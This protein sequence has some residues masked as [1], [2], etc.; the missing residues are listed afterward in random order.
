[1]PTYEYA[2]RDCGEHLEVVQSF[3]DDALTECPSCHGS[4]RK[5]FSAA[6]LIFKGSGWHVKDYAA[7]STSSGKAG[8]GSGSTESSD[9]SSSS[10]SSESTAKTADSGSSGTEKK[11][12]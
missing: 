5:V 3:K 8:T 11:S 10:P 1:M 7:S 4:L 9:T 2:C 6:G 12:A